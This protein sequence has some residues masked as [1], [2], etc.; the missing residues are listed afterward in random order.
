MG[1]HDE[2]WANLNDHPEGWG[3]WKHNPVTEAFF[4]Y[5]KDRSQNEEKWLLEV[6]LAGGMSDSNPEYSRNPLVMRGIVL[7]LRDLTQIDHR[8]IAA[9]YAEKRAEEES[10]R[11]EADRDDRAVQS[12][13][14]TR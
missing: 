7:A 13:P 2:L 4:A 5:I 1:E 9:W 6:F 8:A 11:G 12:D 10:A 14:Q 3:L